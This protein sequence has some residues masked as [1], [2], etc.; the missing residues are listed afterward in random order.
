MSAHLAVHHPIDPTTP[1]F[2]FWTWRLLRRFTIDRLVALSD[3]CPEARALARAIEVEGAT[4][5]DFAPVLAWMGE[6]GLRPENMR[7]LF[8]AS[9]ELTERFGLTP[10]NSW[11][12]PQISPDWHELPI[13]RPLFAG[14]I[15]GVH[16]RARLPESRA[17]IPE[18]RVIWRHRDGVEEESMDLLHNVMGSFLPYAQPI[19]DWLVAR[20]LTLLASA[21]SLPWPDMDHPP[22][23]LPAS[24]WT[25][26]ARAI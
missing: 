18:Y 15:D 4:E 9:A 23:V 19:W 7:D 24:E 6:W 13:G 12:L 14:R 26:L 16:V 25:Q 17:L 2:D 8:L 20:R 10:E 5:V 3:L 22:L 21:G 1:E 11:H